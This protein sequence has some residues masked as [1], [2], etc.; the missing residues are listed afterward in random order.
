MRGKLEKVEHGNPDVDAAAG[1]AAAGAC[2]SLGTASL[3][4]AM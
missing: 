3:S 4:V 1:K 2:P